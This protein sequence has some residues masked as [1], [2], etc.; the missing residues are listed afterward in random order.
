MH[1]FLHAICAKDIKFCWSV[2]GNKVLD[3]CDQSTNTIYKERGY[4]TTPRYPNNYPGALKCSK[5]IQGIEGQ[6]IRVYILDIDLESSGSCADRVYIE[7]DF[8][9]A[10]Y[11]GNQSH[12]LAFKSLGN[13]VTVHFFSNRKGQNKGFWLYYEGMPQFCK[14]YLTNH[15]QLDAP[16]AKPPD[17][18]FAWL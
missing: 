5:T 13:M 1:I 18:K 4:I 9:T 7:G 17:S 12:G 3:I 11:C 15:I 14:V 10:T 6:R 16:V 2:L 8:K